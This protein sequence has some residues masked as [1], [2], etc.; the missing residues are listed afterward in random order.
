MNLPKCEDCKTADHVVE[1]SRNGRY[2]CS[3]CGLV[4]L[5]TLIN[6]GNGI[7]F[8]QPFLSL[9]SEYFK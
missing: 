4:V 2:V 1:D 9:F 8:F 3:K 7:T 6:E 5:N